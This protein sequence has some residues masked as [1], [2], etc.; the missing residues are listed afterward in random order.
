MSLKTFKKISRVIR[1]DNRDTR[2]ERRLLDKFAPIRELWNQWVEILPKLYNP[3]ENVTID[4]QLVAFRGRCPFRQY[5]PSKP[6]KYGI[7]FWVLCDSATS[8]AWNIQ[9]YTGKE[10]G[11]TPER[12]QGMRVVLDLVVGLKGHNLTTDNFF[13]SYQLGQKLLEKQI[14]L[15]ETIRKNKPELPPATVNIKGRP[16]LSS[17]FA[18]T[19]NTTIV[20]YIPKKNKSVNLLS[21]FHHD[22]KVSDRA[23][24]KPAIILDYNKCKGGVDTLDKAVSCYTCKRKTKRWPQVVFSN[25]VDISAYNAFVLFKSANHAWKENC[26]AK[27]RYFLENLGMQLVIPYIQ[28]RQTLPR[29]PFSLEMAK[30]IRSASENNAQSSSSTQP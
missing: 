4:E 29:A 19:R 10:I 22:S 20:S 17:S 16:V 9:P 23:D 27:R 8:Y 28:K 5:I 24:K 21:T 1:F 7:K 13:T 25:M 15:V 14:T 3:S 30:K 18:F 26:L 11:N 2:I 6:A 12:N